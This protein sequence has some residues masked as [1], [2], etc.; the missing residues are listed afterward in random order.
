MLN[1]KQILVIAVEIMLY[2]VIGYFAI[3]NTETEKMVHLQQIFFYVGVAFL[4]IHYKLSFIVFKNLFRGY[5]QDNKAAFYIVL[6]I[7]ASLIAQSKFHY[8]TTLW[9][10]LPE[11][12]TH[13]FFRPQQYEYWIG[14]FNYVVLILSVFAYFLAGY[15]VGSN[16]KSKS[17]V[18]RKFN[19]IIVISH[20]FVILTFAFCEISIFKI[21]LFFEQELPHKILY[22]LIFYLSCIILNYYKRVTPSY[23]FFIPFLLIP[24]ILESYF[25]SNKIK[26]SETFMSIVIAPY[27]LFVYDIF[28]GNV[29]LNYGSSKRIYMKRQLT[30]H[31]L[32][33]SMNMIYS[34]MLTEENHK[35]RE[36]MS[37]F[38]EQM[39]YITYDADKLK[40]ELSKEIK[41]IRDYIEIMKDRFI[42]SDTIN[43]E[44]NMPNE[45][46]SKKVPPLIL[47]PPV[48][49]MF[50]HGI[51]NVNKS[52]LKL[53]ISIEDRKLI[54]L[55]ENTKKNLK[56]ENH[57]KG[58]GL[59]ILKDNL[60]FMY[61]GKHQLKFEEKDDMFY[62]YL[63]IKL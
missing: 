12:E 11:G 35:A 40:I 10:K 54:L 37:K 48:E 28:L 27:Y 1:K 61:P 29:K 49:N 33:N 34:S 24:V 58:K 4:F 46:P 44:V 16:S 55:T 50:K 26:F 36:M 51:S 23:S 42:H 62:L 31:Y 2:L 32:F 47:L 21:E 19:F 17:L 63:S 7:I 59:S 41:F 38:I 56:A 3:R 15:L 39:K 8:I 13:F 30:S 6:L 20:L 25:I 45:L 5:L 9:F 14:A 18:G 60:D 52:K 57:Y 53:D 43:L 22:V